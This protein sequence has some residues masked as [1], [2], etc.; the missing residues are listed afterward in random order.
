M[1]YTKVNWQENT[2]INVAN[3]NN[4]DAGIKALDDEKLDKTHGSASFGYNSSTGRITHNN[5]DVKVLNS[6][7][8]DNATKVNNM[9]VRGGSGLTGASGYITFSW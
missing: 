6:V 3:L 5:N 7:N 2:P 8:A 9:R 4:M 1:A